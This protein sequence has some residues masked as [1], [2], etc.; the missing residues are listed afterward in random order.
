M[1][2]AILRSLGGRDLPAPQK[3]S[4]AEIPDTWAMV[5]LAAAIGLSGL[6]CCFGWRTRH[7][8]R[9]G[10]L[11]WRLTAGRFARSAVL[12]CLAVT[13]LYRYHFAGPPHAAFPTTIQVALPALVASVF[14]LLLVSAVRG[15][16]AMPARTR[17]VASP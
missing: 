6:S 17:E 12:G 3:A 4:R 11:T 5:L 14:A 7:Q 10:R 15:L 16:T 2:R 9:S 1:A 13:L 8:L